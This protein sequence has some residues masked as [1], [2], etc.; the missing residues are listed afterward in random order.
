MV[1]RGRKNLEIDCLKVIAG[2]FKGIAGMCKTADGM[3]FPC[4]RIKGRGREG[5]RR[6][7]KEKRVGK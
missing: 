2:G 6:I 5:S 1:C 4:R 3:F 7:R